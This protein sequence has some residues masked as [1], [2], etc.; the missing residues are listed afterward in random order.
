MD[1]NLLA[2][3]A[4]VQRCQGCICLGT[5]VPSEVTFAP[6]EL[7]NNTRYENLSCCVEGS[8]SPSHCN[9]LLYC[10]LYK[11]RGLINAVLYTML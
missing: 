6:V 9:R 11:Q 1:Q 8:S 5:E 2:F 4:V 3:G 7:V 10:S